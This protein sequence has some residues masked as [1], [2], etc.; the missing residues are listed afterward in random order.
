MK[1]EAHNLKMQGEAVKRLYDEY[2]D[3]K[4][5]LEAIAKENGI[6]R[7][8]V[9]QRFKRAFGDDR[10]R[11]DRKAS[12]LK[13]KKERIESRL[14][15]SI[16]DIRKEHPDRKIEIEAVKICFTKTRESLVVTKIAHRSAEMLSSEQR[17]LMKVCPISKDSKDYN[18]NYFRIT[19]SKR[20]RE[21]DIVIFMLLIDSKYIPYIFKKDDIQVKRILTLRFSSPESEGKY[22]S[23]YQNWNI[24]GSNMVN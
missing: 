13:R 6:S 24:I 19:I 1:K 7:E 16:D 22:Q 11:E 5:T 23:H 20:T 15:T 4:I 17:I 8:A 3:G 10:Y 2:L 9:R 14:Y 21:F 12:A 18:T